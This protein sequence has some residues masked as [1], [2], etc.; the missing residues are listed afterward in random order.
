MLRQL[1]RLTQRRM[2][3]IP[4]LVS[5]DNYAYLL[6]DESTHQ[7]AAVD[8]FDVPKVKAAADQIGVKIVAGIVTHHHL[9][10]TGGNQVN[11]KHISSVIHH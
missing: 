7:A 6:V 3:V 8:P 4:V 1:T 2:K 9:D 5:S 10:H 11:L